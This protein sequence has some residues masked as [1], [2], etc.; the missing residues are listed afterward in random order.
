MLPAS[1]GQ[2]GINSP[3]PGVQDGPGGISAQAPDFGP[4]RFTLRAADTDWQDFLQPA[5]LFSLMQEAAYLNA[6]SLGMGSGALDRRGLCWILI[7]I[8]VRLRF[9]PR[10]GETIMIDT[11][12]RGAQRLI[13]LRDFE[14]YDQS[15]SQFGCASTEWL[16]ASQ[17]THRPLK[18]GDAFPRMPDAARTKQACPVERPPALPET[19][20]GQPVH[21]IRADYSDIDRNRH[22]NNTRYI[23]WCLDAIAAGASLDG[24][25]N[26]PALYVRGID[27]HYVN[28]VFRGTD[29]CC[30]C[31]SEHDG[32]FMRHLVEARAAAVNLPIFRARVITGHGFSSGEF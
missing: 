2:T 30:Y 1:A 21:V 20:F 14:F 25:G 19:A 31:Q 32:P 16:V 10:W 3:V 5:A 4:Y 6:E 27:I 22:V 15:G 12:S 24:G 17:D 8:S 23:A 7:R 11:W 26:L 13:F 29:V 28:E 9:L 18:P